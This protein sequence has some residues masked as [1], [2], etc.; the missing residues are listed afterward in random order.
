MYRFLLRPAW[1]LSHLAVLLLVITMINLG[2]WQLRRLDEKQTLNATIE[3]R[4]D[5][6]PVGVADLI[7][8]DADFGEG[9]DVEFR[10]VRAAGV[11]QVDDEILVHNR[12]LDGAPGRWVLTP[13]L[14]DDGTAIVVNRG[15]V[16][17]SLMPGD[18]RP[19]ADPPSGEV[20]VV[21]LVRPTTT[22][23][24]IQVADP[25]D[26][27]L[28]AL[29]RPDLGRFQQQL[30]YDIYPVLVQLADQTPEQEADL[31]VALRPPELSEGPHLGYA[32]QWFIFAI[33]ALVGYPLVLR[34][35]AAGKAKETEGSGSA[36]TVPP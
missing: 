23:S 35:V 2:L 5:E 20:T 8:V 36:A 6:P 14:L 7:G 31:P 17:F 28:N 1:L 9:D 32:M 13:L 4:A 34:R 25:S 30:D 22:R 26:G 15:W 12:T 11:Y 18:P 27:R 10:T 24:G 29:S 33:I 16:P 21:G 19:E 3:S